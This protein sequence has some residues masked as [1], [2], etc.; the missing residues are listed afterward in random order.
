MCHRNFVFILSLS[1][2]DVTVFEKLMT[3]HEQFSYFARCRNVNKEQ[4]QVKL[5]VLNRLM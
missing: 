3:P 4:R 1:I 5:F 2:N